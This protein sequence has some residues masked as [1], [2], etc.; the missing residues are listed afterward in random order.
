MAS[1]PFAAPRALAQIDVS[2]PVG[3]LNYA[4]TLEHLESAFYRDGLEGFEDADFEAGVIDNLLLIADH[5][6]EHVTTL[7]GVI[8]SLGGTPVEEATYDF[9][10]AY[11]DPATF[12]ATAQALENT[13]VAA[14]TGAAQFLIAEDALL[15][16]ALTIHGVEARHAAYLNR[17]NGAVPFPD[18]VDA[19]STPDEIL[20]IAGPFIVAAPAPA[21]VGGTTGSD[22]TANATANATGATTTMTAPATGVGSGFGGEGG[23]RDSLPLLGA[24][25][26]AAAGLAY[27]ARRLQTATEA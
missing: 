24:A 9:G 17:L 1:L 23:M 11:D 27:V 12:L 3:V 2:T 10:G 18:A 19:P 26:A 16:A 14:Y 13:G 8:E 25:G 21:A 22:A 20:A 4:L 15:T 6:A 7:I 5:E